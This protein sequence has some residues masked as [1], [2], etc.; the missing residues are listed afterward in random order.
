[1]T[2]RRQ[3]EEGQDLGAA[4]S[5]DP[6]AQPAV[7]APPP[8]GEGTAPG[9]IGPYVV[10]GPL[11]RGGSASVLVVHDPADGRRLALKLLH[12][13]QDDPSVR[14]RFRR[15]FR[16]L[17]RLVHPNV[18]HV[19]TWGIHHGRPWFTMELVRGRDLREVVESW[20]DLAPEDRF[21]RVHDVLVQLT[22][23]LAYIHERGLVHRDVSPG[24]VMVGEDG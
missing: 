4:A 17:Q 21:A 20:T 5:P 7:E 15:E 10:E 1:M 12:P 18:L 22:R 11:G 19:E 14:S 6:E 16:A 8:D 13:V 23:A 3:S 2:Q 24:N 9:T